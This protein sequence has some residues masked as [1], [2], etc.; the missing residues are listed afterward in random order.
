MRRHAE[1][2]LRAARDGVA[3]GK[4]DALEILHF[5]HDLARIHQYFDHNYSDASR[6]YEEIRTQ[7][8]ESAL[9]NKRAAHLFAAATRNL[10]ECILDPAGRPVDGPVFQR[11]ENLLHEGIGVAGAQGLTQVELE[12]VYTRARLY[13]AAGNDIAAASFLLDLSNGDAGLLPVPWTR[14]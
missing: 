10:A 11:I 9:T 7:L 13:E 12:L 8:S 4:F 6:D 2:A 3:E 1:S 14:G 5:Q